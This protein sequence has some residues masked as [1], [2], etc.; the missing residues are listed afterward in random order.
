MRRNPILYGIVCVLVSCLFPCCALL[1]GD[2]G[3]QQDDVV[4]VDVNWT[5]P[6]TGELTPVDQLEFPCAPYDLAEGIDLDLLRDLG[7]YHL[8][9]LN[10]DREYF[11]VE[12][13]G[14]APLIWSDTLWMVALCYA[15]DMCD[16]QYFSHYSPE[17]ED[18]GDRIDEV[19]SQDRWAWGENLAYSWNSMISNHSGFAVF[20]TVVNGHQSGYMD[21]CQCN[22]G[23]PSGKIA[24]HR[25]NILNPDF[26]EVGI[27]QW[28]C[29][30]EG[31]FYN[32]QVF[33]RTELSKAHHNSY[34]DGGFTA[35]PPVPWTTA[36]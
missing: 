21:E 17:G 31:S 35:D 26:T 22:D 16:R 28:Y 30:E 20:Q 12:S 1:D 34:C 23:C 5:P 8:G 9:L 4:S 3:N 32:V 13:D 29:A 19:T 25:T 2:D 6:E 10:A 27:A 18:V 15:R 11:D 24:G 7:L 14:A 33:W 36:H